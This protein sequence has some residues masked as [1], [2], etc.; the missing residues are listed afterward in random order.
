MTPREFIQKWKD[1]AL[2]ER[3]SAQ[4]HFI[5]L[6][7]MLGHP[8]PAEDD[9]A[10]ERFTFEKGL[11]K[12]GGGGGYADVWKRGHFAWEY[13]KRRRN[14]D[15]ALRPKKTRAALTREAADQLQTISNP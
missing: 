2:T 13:K 4:E 3:A 15:E 10:G 1:H 8:T 11:I 12:T 9:P 5:D 7:R 14:L 6:C